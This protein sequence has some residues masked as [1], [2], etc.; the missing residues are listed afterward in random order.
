LGLAGILWLV[1][2]ACVDS[3]ERNG[4]EGTGPAGTVASGDAADDAAVAPDLQPQIEQ[5]MQ[6]LA[7]ELGVDPNS[8]RVLEARRVTWSSGA[9]GCPEP[10]SGYTQALV[11]GVFIVLGADGK[12][13]LYHAGAGGQPFACPAERAEP[14]L[15]AAAEAERL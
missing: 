13:F 8:I 10:E 9:L 12:T 3:G 4:A 5:A 6:E 11:P 7:R 1:L 2:T 14:P 15:P